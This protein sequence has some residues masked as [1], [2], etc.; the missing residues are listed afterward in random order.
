MALATGLLSVSQL[1]EVETQSVLEYGIER[2]QAAIVAELEA[3]NTKM[4]DMIGSMC[5]MT[6]KRADT[7][8]A[9]TGG[10]MV[11]TDEFGRAP[12]QMKKG[13]GTIHHPLRQFQYNIGWTAN[14][15]KVSSPADLARQTQN[16][17]L[18]HRKMVIS[19]I[20]QAIYKSSNYTHYDHL[21]DNYALPVKRLL[22]A[23]SVNIPAGPNGETFT[24]ST[25][26]HY[27]AADWSTANA[28]AKLAAAKA[29]VTDVVEHGHG[30]EKVIVVIALAD[31][32]DMEDVSIFTAYQDARLIIKASDQPG[33][34]L[35]PTKLDNMPIGVLKGTAAEVWVKPWGVAD[36]WL[37]TDAGAPEDERMLAFRQR[38]SKAAQGL[39][40]A[41]IIE[42][43]PL[44]AQYMTAEFGFGV[45]YRSNGAVLYTG[46]AAWTDATSL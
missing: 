12:T 14:F 28:A 9:A 41:S 26:T 8:G 5:K 25:H 6:T 32:S 35:N 44:T 23:D 30:S 38:D 15:A 7:W 45:N 24:G 42:N 19:Q 29:L 10:Q 21:V 11:E 13:I 3:H 1:L 31:V 20:R 22:N 36:Y 43:F 46:G 4:V 17:E 27:D 37:C 40:L 39:Q 2:V 34:M 18:A 33:K 16:A